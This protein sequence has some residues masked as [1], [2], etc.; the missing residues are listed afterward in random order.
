MIIATADPRLGKILAGVCPRILDGS[1]YSTAPNTASQL[2]N[3]ATVLATEYAG[4]WSVSFADQQPVAL[5]YADLTESLDAHDSQDFILAPANIGADST[6]L[7]HFVENVYCQ[8]VTPANWQRVLQLFRIWYAA[9]CPSEYR[10]PPDGASPKYAA[11]S[12]KDTSEKRNAR[13]KKRYDAQRE[14]FA[15]RG[16]KNP[17]AVLTAMMKGEIEIPQNPKAEKDGNHE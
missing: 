1:G 7:E 8:P 15:A 14:R 6:D 10:N 17:S 9:T 5:G 13:T 3:L 12:L 16:W 4:L 2:S 11:L